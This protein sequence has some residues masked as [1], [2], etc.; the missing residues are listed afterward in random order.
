MTISG[1][2]TS[3]DGASIAYQD[4]GA[5]PA[6]VLVHGYIGNQRLN[7]NGPGVFDALVKAGRR[8][9]TLDLRGHGKS[10]KPHDFGAYEDRAL[11]RDVVAAADARGLEA[12]DLVG[13]SL[14]AIVVGS[15]AQLD[16]RVRSLVLGGLGHSV[17]DPAWERPAQLVAALTGEGDAAEAA[18]AAM[19]QAIESMGGDRR[20]LAGVQH[21]HVALPAHDLATIRVPTL[22][23]C[24]DADDVNG[25]P[26]VLT[27]A[28][29]SGR[30][31]RIPG[32]HVGAL[33]TDD[34]QRELLAFLDE[35]SPTGIGIV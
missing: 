10:D 21:G 34:F 24:G 19:V 25:D 16:P 23:L 17:M 31:V 6:V 35:V 20:A 1:S 22:V 27:A 2:F 11:A 9:V 8:V 4:D 14:G 3:F 13:Y 33:S 26:A 32:D 15:V 5:G 7:W 29:P 12:Y 28:I 30:L 18:A